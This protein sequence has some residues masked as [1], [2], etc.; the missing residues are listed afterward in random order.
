M[1]FGVR[2]YRPTTA[3]SLG[4]SS[5]EAGP[6]LG[7]E[8]VRR[9]DAV[10]RDLRLRD[11]GGGHDAA[12]DFLMRLDQLREPAHLAADDVVGQDHREGLVA[13]EVRGAGHGVPQSQRLILAHVGNFSAGHACAAHGFERV[14]LAGRLE[15]RLQIWRVVEEV[16]QR[17]LA[18]RGHEY[19]VLDAR[20]AG[21]LYGVVN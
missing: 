15:T 1:M 20:C 3:R 12:A 2:I 18:A 17:R 7:R 9:D 13:D 6:R 16:A 5:G 11:A 14:P 4:A 21:L 19:E 10:A 8:L